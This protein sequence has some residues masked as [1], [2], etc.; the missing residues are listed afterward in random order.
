[1]ILHRQ[2]MQQ[3]TTEMNASRTLRSSIRFFFEKSLRM[4]GVRLSAIAYLATAESRV[5]L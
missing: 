2:H 4:S 1:M 3:L 5:E